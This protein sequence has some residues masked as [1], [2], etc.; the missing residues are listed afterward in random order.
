MSEQDY[1]KEG[2]LT[3][4]TDA[5]TEGTLPLMGKTTGETLI[6]I[7]GTIAS[8]RR[9]EGLTR[10][11][12]FGLAAV[13]E[14]GPVNTAELEARVHDQK[15]FKR[16]AHEIVSDH[17]YLADPSEAAVVFA[18]Y[19][20]AYGIPASYVFAVSKDLVSGKSSGKLS[21]WAFSRVFMGDKQKIIDPSNAKKYASKGILELHSSDDYSVANKVYV[22]FAEGL[23]S[24]DMAIIGTD[25]KR[26]IV[27]KQNFRLMLPDI[28]TYLSET[29]DKPVQDG[30]SKS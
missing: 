27:D 14:D 8:F 6:G 26:S 7:L 3:K 10:A 15:L 9:F 19:C 12:K 24:R 29:K 22:P 18:T 17:G 25:T 2:P 30:N 13:S 5:I 16:T 21:Y 1:L 28:I 4:I 23:D 20:R 11:S